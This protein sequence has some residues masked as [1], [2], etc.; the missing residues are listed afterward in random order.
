MELRYAIVSPVAAKNTP[1]EKIYAVIRHIPLGKVA[2]YGQVAALA[3]LPGRARLVGTALREAPEGLDVPWQ[4]VINAGGRVSSRGGLGIEEGYQRHLLEEEGVVFDSHGRID[5]ERFGWDPEAAPRGRAKGK[6]RGRQGPDAEVRA[7]AAILRPLGTPE[8]AEG[9]K[10]YLKSDLDFLGVTTPD[11]R[12]AVHHW[13]A[14]HPRLDRPALVAL[15]GALWATPCHELR[16]FGMELL[17]LRLPLLESGDAGLLE[18]LL[19]RSGSWAYVDFLAVQVMGPLVERDPRLNAVLDRWVKDPDFWLRRS[20]VLA[21]LLPLRRGG[22]D[23]P[24]F[25]RYADRLLEEKEFFIRKAL[26]WV[27]REV[28]KKHPERVRK[29]LREREGRLSGVTRREAEKYL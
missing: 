14:A 17:Q 20:A 23:W 28:S 5:L 2:T 19:R 7:I 29:F 27:L 8:R 21:L 6:G 4:R 11:L 26:G 1:H 9:S 13:L 22:G 25:V 24:R 10:S 3:G 15:A 16:A 18:D 12:A